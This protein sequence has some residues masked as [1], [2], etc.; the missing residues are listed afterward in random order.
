[1]LKYN[2][3]AKAFVTIRLIV[4][5]DFGFNFRNRFDLSISILEIDSKSDSISI[6]LKSNRIVKKSKIILFCQNF[7]FLNLHY[8]NSEISLD[9]KIVYFYKIVTLACIITKDSFI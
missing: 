6:F 5:S 2:K 7:L 9:C 3:Y 1:L 8:N 4:G